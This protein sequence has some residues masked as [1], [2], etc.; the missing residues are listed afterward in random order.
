MTTRAHS[1]VADATEEAMRLFFPTGV[2]EPGAVSADIAELIV[3]E[4]KEDLRKE[5]PGWRNESPVSSSAMRFRL[6]F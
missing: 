2:P 5:F 3:E 6:T 1:D 4:A